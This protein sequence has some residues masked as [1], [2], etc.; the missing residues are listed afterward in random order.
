MKKNRLLFVPFLIGLF[1]MLYSWFSCYPL[2]VYSANDQIFY[3][4]SFLYWVSLPL[5][6]GSMFLIALTFENK[7]LK[8][9]MAVGFVLTLYSLGSVNSSGGS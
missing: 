6:L 5:L 4:V 3:H 1:L 9:A 7:F 8:W 2:S